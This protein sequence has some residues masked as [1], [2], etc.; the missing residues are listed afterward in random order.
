MENLVSCTEG[1]EGPDFSHLPEVAWVR[2]LRFLAMKDRMSVSETCHILHEIFNHPSL[3]YSQKLIFMGECDN[4]SRRARRVFSGA[5]YV[6]LVKRYGHCFQD[7]MI[8]VMGHFTDIPNDLKDVLSQISDKCRLE[9]LTIDAGVVTSRF[10]ERY[11]YP[12]K[13]EGVKALADFVR[14]AY[15]M[16]HLHI[17]SW[18]MYNKMDT[19]ECNIFKVLISNE[20]L[21]RTLETLVIFGIEETEWSEREPKL[22]SDPSTTLN[23]MTKFKNITTLGLRSFM[24]SN[25]L[26]LTLSEPDRTKLDVLNILVHYI[27]QDPHEHR[28]FQVPNI[29]PSSWSALSQ[30]NPKFRVE[31]TIFLQTP[32]VELSNMLSPEVPLSSLVFM[33]YSKIDPQTLFRAYTHHANTIVKFRS[34]C[35]SYDLDSEVLTLNQRCTKLNEFVY[36]GEIHS[37]TVVDLAQSKGVKWNR[38]EVRR[39]K[40]KVPTEFD[41]YGEDDVLARDASGQLVSV[42]LMKFHQPE[43]EKDAH[44]A[45]MTSQVSSALDVPWRPNE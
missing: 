32:D 24:L 44:I 13:S 37:N 21:H 10:H 23:L 14:N 34:F 26:I 2:V 9:S 7:L 4:F 18:P 40:I 20:K 5:N 42:A 25:D 45:N 15:K 33:K 8:Q 39:E 27:R 16:K 35:D 28:E 19:D 12:P 17:K 30:R 29:R 3:W 22:F 43:E 36:H 38:F 41:E 11:G 1:T 6:E 31:C